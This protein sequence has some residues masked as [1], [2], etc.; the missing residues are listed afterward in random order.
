MSALLSTKPF[1]ISKHNLKNLNNN[2]TGKTNVDFRMKLD[3]SVYTPT[4]HC[5]YFIIFS[6]NYAFFFYVKTLHFIIKQSLLIAFIF[7]MR[8]G[9]LHTAVLIQWTKYTHGD[10]HI[11]TRTGTGKHI[12]WQL[13]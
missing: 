4:I 2:I 6:A 3:A 8:S 1:N 13:I 5:V 9:L 10:R 7:C 11:H 12:Q